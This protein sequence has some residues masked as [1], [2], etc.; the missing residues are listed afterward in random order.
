MGPKYLDAIKTRLQEKTNQELLDIWTKN[1]RREWSSDAFDAIKTIL[2]E[3]NIP[4]P[5]Q[6]P[7][8]GSTEN[9]LSIWKV[10]FSFVGRIPRQTFWFVIICLLGISILFTFFSIIPT[11]GKSEALIYSFAYILY[12][13]L[14]IWISFA[15]QIKRWH[16]L[17]KSG[18]WMFINFLP[19][20]GL[21]WAFIKL[22]CTRGTIG[23]NQY[24]EDPLNN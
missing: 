6:N 12:W 20:I 24:G 23:P 21:I 15:V 9:Y 8:L 3:R 22:G 14:I 11:T 5:Q 10:L 18:W 16:D 4:L 1:D 19:I 7:Y 2:T 17:D 13:I